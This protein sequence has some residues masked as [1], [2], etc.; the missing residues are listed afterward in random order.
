MSPPIFTDAYIRRVCPENH[1][2]PLKQVKLF[3][4]TKLPKYLANGNS[5]IKYVPH[6]IATPG[7]IDYIARSISR[8]VQGRE[9]EKVRNVLNRNMTAFQK[10]EQERVEQK[11]MKQKIQDDTGT[12]SDYGLTGLNKYLLTG[13]VGLAT[14]L[15]YYLSTST[16]PPNNQPENDEFGNSYDEE[17]P[18]PDYDSPGSG[19]GSYL[20]GSTPSSADTERR[21]ADQTIDEGTPLRNFMEALDLNSEETPATNVHFIGAQGQVRRGDLVNQRRNLDDDFAFSPGSQGGGTP[22]SQGGGTPGSQGGGTPGSQG[23]GTPGSQG[24]DMSPATIRK[25]QKTQRELKKLQTRLN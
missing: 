6:P 22:G 12:N 21:N 23:G 10:A 9:K 5:G 24:G 15:A 16:L 3:E 8:E 2:V 18:P 19:G 14:G 25:Q 1:P 7:R 4:Q 11:R 13:G 17:N 20:G